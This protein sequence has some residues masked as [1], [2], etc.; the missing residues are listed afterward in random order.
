M[1]VQE[2]LS[3]LTETLTN[4][5]QEYG[6]S[7]ERSAVLKRVLAI[8]DEIELVETDDGRTAV[9]L[10]DLPQPDTVEEQALDGMW[11]RFL[12]KVGRA[13]RLTF[14]YRAAHTH[15]ESAVD[16]YRDIVGYAA[17]MAMFCTESGS[18]KFVRSD[19]AE[20]ETDGYGY[21]R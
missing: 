15:F 2:F 13:Y 7:N 17:R 19:D 21:D 20:V 10:A 16:S 9:V 14:V 6:P 4:K 8:D 18:G 1:G 3:D 5:H 12:D 11:T